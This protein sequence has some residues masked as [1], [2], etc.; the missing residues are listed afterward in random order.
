MN[1]ST[2]TRI[3]EVH[4]VAD[5]DASYRKVLADV[6][7][8]KDEVTSGE[9]QSV[10][11]KRASKEILHYNLVIENPRERLI[12]NPQRPINLPAAVARFVWMMAG[13]DRLKDIEFYEP[14]AAF[15]TDDGIVMPG[16]CYG[17]R[18]IYPAPGCNQILGIVERLKRDIATRRAAISVYRAED[19]VRESKDIPCTFGLA[20][21]NRDGFLHPSVVMRSN[22]AFILLPYNIFEFSMLGEVIAAEVGLELGAMSYYAMSMHVYANDYKAAQNVI[23]ADLHNPNKP[24]P[25]MPRIPSPLGQIQE[26]VK[27]EANARHA[28]AGFSRTDFEAKWVRCADEKLDPYWRQFYYLLLLAMCKKV[29]FQQG[30][31]MLQ[32]FIDDPWLSCLPKETFASPPVLVQRKPAAELD[33]F[34][35]PVTR[36]GKQEF[37]TTKLPAGVSEN[38]Y[39]VS[40]AADS[41][42]ISKADLEKEFETLLQLYKPYVARDQWSQVTEYRSKF[43]SAAATTPETTARVVERLR[44]LKFS[45]LPKEKVQSNRAP[46]DRIIEELQKLLV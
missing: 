37:R 8:T 3:G 30:V 4:H 26:L 23:D 15:F 7:G 16:S 34:G 22:N 14:K 9:T 44:K 5:A 10:G 45:L 33:L 21:H 39:P 13:N 46:A 35:E 40:N 18:M 2:A 41:T 38:A 24:I 32:E 6:I 17:H 36:T 42:I 20:F 29:N 19:A 27:I 1:R 12:W 31:M 28:A 25:P 11:S 43:L